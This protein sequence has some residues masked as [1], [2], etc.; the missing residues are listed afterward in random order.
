MS[1]EIE[2]ICASNDGLDAHLILFLK[3]LISKIFSYF[4]KFLIGPLCLINPSSVSKVG[5]NL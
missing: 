4:F 5:S 1:S 2:A 3:Y